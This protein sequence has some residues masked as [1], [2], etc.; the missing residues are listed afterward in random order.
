MDADDE[1]RFRETAG[2]PMTPAAGGVIAGGLVQPDQPVG[3]PRRRA[4]VWALAG[5]VAVLAIAVTSVGVAIAVKSGDPVAGPQPTESSAPPEQ[6]FP[7]DAPATVAGAGPCI[8]VPVLSSFENSDMVANLAA[9]YN[10]VPRDVDG[11]CV[12]VSA[13]KD[14]S[15]VSAT[16]AADGF[17]DL[18]ADQRPVMWI[19]DASSWLSAARTQGA[20]SVPAEGT[21]IASSSVVLAMPAPLAE[22]IGWDTDAPTWSDVFDAAD[23]DAVWSDLDHPEW[24]AFK[25]GKT[26]PLVATSG[27][28]ALLASFDAAGEGLGSSAASDIADGDR[29]EAVR[30]HELATSHYMATPEHFLWHARE[31]EAHGSS[32][33]FLSGVIVDEKSVWDYNRGIVSRDGV[34]R[35]QGEPPRDP[36]VP[37]Y[38]SDGFYAADNPAV[39]L[40]GDWID[41]AERAGAD[42]FLRFLGTA[43]A[44]QI[45][46]DSGYRDLHGDLAPT[47]Q[48]IGRLAEAP[49]GAVALPGAK[50]IAALHDSFAEVRKRASVLFLIDVS[51]SM[52]EAIPSGQS[53]LDAAKSAIIAA[54]DHFSAGDEVGLAAFSSAGDANLTPGLVTPVADIAENRDALVAAVGTLAPQSFTPLYAAV[55][56]FTTTQAAAYDPDRITAVVVLSD[57]ANETAVPLIDEAGLLAKLGE[58]HHHS[59]VLVFTLAYGADADIATLQRISAASGAHFY[60]ATDPAKVTAVLGDLVT[61]F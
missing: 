43:E 10:A 27:E 1:P 39:V 13:A 54:L 21:P 41:E 52:A 18:P 9:G 38:P 24:G 29:L 25:L 58:L 33:D 5:A 45:V 16:R 47:V 28:A 11:S 3:S 50:E 17:A 46:R 12:T 61:S 49:D 4:A 51:G 57:G 60:D 2:R 14:K 59:P 7:A 20:S 30:R 32:A 40:D 37:I 44:Q 23:D 15:G 26:S 22:T 34:T 56:Q 31:A 35:T 36:L 55:D 6:P 48:D 53:K 42:D 8:L 19:P